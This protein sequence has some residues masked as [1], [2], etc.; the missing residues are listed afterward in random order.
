MKLES[1]VKIAV[2]ATVAAMV[3]ACGTIKKAT[4]EEVVEVKVPTQAEADSILCTISGADAGRALAFVQEKPLAV[5][6]MVNH[7]DSAKVRYLK[8]EAPKGEWKVSDDVT[9]PCGDELGLPFMNVADSAVIRKIAGEDYITYAVQRGNDKEIARTVV[10]FEPATKAMSTVSFNGKPM[11]GGKFRGTSTKNIIVDPTR[12]QTA[13]AIER[14]E[15]YPDLM[16][17]SEG[18]IMTDQA[19][20]WWLAKNPKALTSATKITFGQLP[21]ESSLVA[22]YEK[23]KKEKGEKFYA[24]Q[25]D[26]D[27]YAMVVAKNRSTGQYILAWVEP[28]C[29]NKKTDRLLNSVYFASGSNLK[30][31]YYKGKTTFTY[32]LNLANGALQR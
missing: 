17:M 30:L 19:I 9:L 8:L 16:F 25:V 27:D 24:A 5:L 2:F 31:Y 7:A 28:Q 32:W 11:K 18:E 23:A 10:T 14:L 3:A 29:K 21:A 12:P 1:I 13:W 22:L 6:G 15:S 4:V 26:T 20:E